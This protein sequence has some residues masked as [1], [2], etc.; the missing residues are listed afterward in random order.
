MHWV[1][2]KVKGIPKPSAVLE[3]FCGLLSEERAARADTRAG[4]RRFWTGV[5]LERSTRAYDKFP[6]LPQL[7]D[8]IDRLDKDGASDDL[9]REVWERFRDEAKNAGLPGAPMTPSE[10]QRGPRAGNE[11]RGNE[12]TLAEASE[13]YDI[14]RPTWTKAAQLEPSEYGYLPTRRVGRNRF[15]TTTVAE[16]FAKDYEARREQRAVGSKNTDP[17]ARNVVAS[18][19]KLKKSAPRR[20][21]GN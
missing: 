8:E 15:V 21:G 12:Y 2:R 18:L 1:T 4:H 19:R 3:K 6:E 5:A 17:D 16:K 11:Q 14:P 9:L 7:A 10:V 20:R 13:K